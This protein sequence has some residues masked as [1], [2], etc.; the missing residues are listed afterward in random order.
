MTKWFGGLEFNI[1]IDYCV[2]THLKFE[3]IPG[4]VSIGLVNK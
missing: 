4:I 3:F 1:Q 2:L